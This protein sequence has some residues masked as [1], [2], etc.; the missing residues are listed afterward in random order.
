[1]LLLLLLR[2]FA[3]AEGMKRPVLTDE[4]KCP[5][6]IQ[7]SAV[8]GSGCCG[9]SETRT[10]EGRESHPLSRA[11]FDDRPKGWPTGGLLKPEQKRAEK[12]EQGGCCWWWPRCGVQVARV[13]M[14]YEVPPFW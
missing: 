1:M 8:G 7:R 12:E 6:S 9:C 2:L 4:E 10:E 11:L 3:A 14:L 13:K 5:D